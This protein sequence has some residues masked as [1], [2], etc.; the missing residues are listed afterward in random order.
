[1]TRLIVHVEGQ[2]EEEFVKQ[3]LAPYLWPYAIWAR[4][5]L[6]GNS[7]RHRGGITGWT[8]ARNEIVRH[9]KQDRNCIVTTMVDFYG[10]PDEEGKAWPN[11]KEASERHVSASERA[12]FVEKALLEDIREQMGGGFNGR[13]FVPYLMMHEFEAML[14][15]DCA[16]F[17]AAIGQPSLATS[18]Q[19]IRNGFSCPEEI[20]DTPDGAPSKRI[21]QLFGPRRYQKP[22]R[23][24]QGV[25]AIGLPAIRAECPH[26][27]CWLS[28]LENLSAS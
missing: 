25:K 7:R 22:L 18:F 10:L 26:F 17:S 23:G 19:D 3:V 14:F 4:V 9:L 13:R 16:K 6:L 20:N 12:R 27:S 28:R 2:T 11:R 24:V 5:T 15:S 21:E 8:R 1:M